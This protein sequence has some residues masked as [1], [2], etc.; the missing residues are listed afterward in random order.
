MLPGR[1]HPPDQQDPGG[2]LRRAVPRL[3]TAGAVHHIQDRPQ[4][5]LHERDDLLRQARRDWKDKPELREKYR[6]FRPNVERVI[7]QIANLGGRRLK[8]RYRGTTKNH[9]WLKRRTASL[10]LRNL[11]GRGLTLTAGVWVLAAQ[12]A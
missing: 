12:T 9:A 5:V 11:I 2:D 3:P 6:T 4:I 1:S 10:N 8:S 7:S